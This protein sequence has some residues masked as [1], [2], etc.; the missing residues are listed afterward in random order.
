MP[1]DLDAQGCNLAQPR[2]IGLGRGRAGYTQL[3]AL[4][5]HG[6]AARI[7]ET[8]VDAGGAFHA[9]AG[10]AE[11]LQRAD[12]RIFDA[13]HVFLD[14][15]AQALQIQQR[16]GDHLARAV[17][18]DLPAAVGCD[19][20]NVARVQQVVT[21]PGKALR[22]MRGVLADPELVARAGIAAARECLHGLH[23]GFVV[24]T[25]QQAQVQRLRKLGGWGAQ[26]TTFTS[27]CEV[28]A[29][30]RS[31]S[32]SR[33]V[34]VTV[35]V[36]PRYLPLLLG[37]NSMVLGSKAGSK[38]SAIWVISCTRCSA[39]MPMTLMGNCDGYSINESLRGS[40]PGAAAGAE[41]GVGASVIGESRLIAW[42]WRRLCAIVRGHVA[43]W[44]CRAA[45]HETPHTTNKLPAVRGWRCWPAA[46]QPGC[47]R[48]FGHARNNPY[49]SAGV[50]TY[51]Q[52]L[53]EKVLSGLRPSRTQ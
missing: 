47:R 4:G 23:R 18:G 34:A 35:T 9:V 48:R 46:T 42:R 30:Y 12:D 43:A 27:G 44:G 31:S 17:V 7:V 19:H 33:L 2:K 25:A 13:E 40:A 15:V 24:G 50:F 21:F 49:R 41:E 53:C 37:R 8:H 1:A 51:N 22:E 5:Q 6:V 11:M 29:W 38:R 3:R 20:G 39:L 52:R 36:T 28:N 10:D 32:C 14:E 16:I 26:S 45:G